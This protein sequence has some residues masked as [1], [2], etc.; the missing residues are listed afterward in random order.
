MGGLLL[1]EMAPGN[2]ASRRLNDRSAKTEDE[3]IDS[4]A[5]WH[6]AVA[7]SDSDTLAH[8]REKL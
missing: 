6:F 1:V 7:R 3:S 4:F 5:Q 2:S 8:A